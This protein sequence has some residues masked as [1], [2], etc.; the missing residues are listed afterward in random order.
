MTLPYAPDELVWAIGVNKAGCVSIAGGREDDLLVGST[1][2]AGELV[3][4]VWRVRSIAECFVSDVFA[5]W[6][7]SG[8][9]AYS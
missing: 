9:K 2:P 7:H 5:K 4:L 3:R 6:M 8:M 1:E